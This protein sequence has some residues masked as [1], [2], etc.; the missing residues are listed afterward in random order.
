[1]SGQESDSVV[2][3]GPVGMG[4]QGFPGRLAGVVKVN[5]HDRP[6]VLAFHGSL[7]NRTELIPVGEK[8]SSLFERL[9]FLYLQEGISIFQRLR[10]EFALSLWDGR[11]ETL[12]LASDRFRVHPLFYYQDES[13]LLF[14]SRVKSLLNCPL[15]LETAISPEAVVDVVTSSAIPTP[16]TIFREV[17]KLPPGHVLT[18]H[19]SVI[20]VLPYWEVNFLQPSNEGEGEL[21][22]QL[23]SK[24][25]EAVS[26]RLQG[27]GPPSKVGTF[28]SGGVDS[29]TVTGV[30]TQLT[31]QPVKSFTIGFGE[32]RFNEVSYARIAAQA[33]GAEHYEYFVTP[34][35]AYAAI[36]TLLET[37][38]EPFANA[39]AIPTYF[40]AKLAREHGVD[41][42]YAGDGGDEL[43]AGNDRYA[44]QRVFEYYDNVPRWL[45]ESLVK[46]VTFAL[47]EN[48]PW[49]LFVKGK[50]YIERASVPYPERL[51]SYSFANIL[52]LANLLTDDFVESVGKNYEPHA[53]TRMYYLQ[54]PAK[55]ELD[56]QLYIDLKRAISD[57]D[58]FKVTRMTEAA[59]VSVRYPFLDSQLVEFAVTVPAHM[60]MRGRQLRTFFKKAYADLLPSEVR[61]KTKHGF[62]LPIPVWLRTD[63]RLNDLMHDL[64]LSPQSI[65]RG[66]FRKDALETLVEHHRTDETSF[67]GTVLWNF[68]ILELWHRKYTGNR[69]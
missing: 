35:D 59:G 2:L 7:Y 65:Q 33:F 1:M 50:K 55:T 37:F 8:P 30:L 16:R 41:T 49:P 54:A 53:S 21:A 23:R 18:Y 9:L 12:Y 29:T 40:C 17:K 31:K 48:L 26:V 24:F 51:W 10:G 27:E 4:A 43:F 39:S 13:Q 44:A 6:F 45:R 64:V 46:P 36:P 20:D 61:A 38:D 22:R 28:L 60:K 69:N 42:L 34:Q 66:Y 14:A 11:H 67:Y 62:G 5:I 56:R 15:R 25:A 32:P 57:N 19:N 52:P 3:E 68:M 47:A 58:L 63:K